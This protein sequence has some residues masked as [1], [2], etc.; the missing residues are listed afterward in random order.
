MVIERLGRDPLKKKTNTGGGKLGIP[1]RYTVA[2]NF[3]D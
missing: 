3:E 1:G 2:R